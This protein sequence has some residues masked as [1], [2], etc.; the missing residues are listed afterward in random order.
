MDDGYAIGPAHVVFGAIDRFA[1][2]AAGLGLELRGDKCKCFS[3][4]VDLAACLERPQRMPIGSLATSSG[5]MGYGLAV[6]GVPIGDDVFVEA[7]LESKVA[8]AMSKT[9]QVVSQLRDMLL[10]YWVQHCYPSDI[11]PHAIAMDGN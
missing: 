3:F 8:R 9:D 5:R 7:F 1:E 4:G 10:H 6:G 11:K 2:A